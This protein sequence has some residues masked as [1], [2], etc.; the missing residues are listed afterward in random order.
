MPLVFVAVLSSYTTYL[1]IYQIP[2]THSKSGTHAPAAQWRQQQ[3]LQQAGHPRAA[4]MTAKG[5]V[6]DTKAGVPAAQAAATQGKDKATKV[7]AMAA[8]GKAAEAN[9]AAGGSSSGNGGPKPATGPHRPPPMA[10]VDAATRWYK[11]T[12]RRMTV[13]IVNE[14]PYHLE[15]VAGF[16]HVLGQLPVDVTWYQAGQEHPPYGAIELLELVGFVKLLGYMPRM[17]PSTA[18]PD[19]V[20]F[21]VF[22]SPEYFEKQTQVTDVGRASTCIG[23][24][25]VIRGASCRAGHKADAQLSHRLQAQ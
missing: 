6:A 11:A 8:A 19:P 13:A 12:G 20:D 14:A 3:Q 9:T 22:I 18:K 15:I 2:R 5:S 25:W 1:M 7:A 10:P 24:M 17:L 16:L 4:D 23:C 21:A